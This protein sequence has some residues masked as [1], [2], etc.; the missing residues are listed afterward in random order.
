MNEIRV[1]LGRTEA[2]VPYTN[3]KQKFLIER[4][5]SELNVEFNTLRSSLKGVDE[6]ILLFFLLFKTQ[7]DIFQ[8][9]GVWNCMGDI[10]EY[11]VKIFHEIS[12]FICNDDK[13]REKVGRML[14]AV[15]IYKRMDL[16]NETK[17]KTSMNAKEA[18]EEFIFK[19]KEQIKLTEDKISLL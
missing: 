18:M 7:S 1:T 19:T 15:N 5:V 14:V 13:D 9:A 16:T 3:E 11:F 8:K 12:P 2:E 4:I 17:N 6:V 10:N